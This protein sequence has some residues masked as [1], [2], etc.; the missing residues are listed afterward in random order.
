MFALRHIFKNSHNYPLN[1]SKFGIGF[2]KYIKDNFNSF[3]SSINI[4]KENLK[5]SI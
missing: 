5:N 2:N 1:F 3:S 4:S